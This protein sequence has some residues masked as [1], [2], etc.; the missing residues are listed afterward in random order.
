MAEAVNQGV[1]D[2]RAWC[3]AKGIPL[4]PP[5]PVPPRPTTAVTSLTFTEQMTGFLNPGTTSQTLA[6]YEA[7]AARAKASNSPLTVRLDVTIQDVNQFV[8]SP[9][10]EAVAAGYVDSPLVGGRAAVSGG[11]I[12]LLVD[13]GDPTKKQM[14]YRLIFKGVDGKDYTL[15]GFKDISGAT[16]ASAW[17]ET[18]TLYTT[19]LSGAVPEGAAGTTA[20]SGVISIQP[21][22]FFFR[23]L[24]S[25]RVQGPTLAAQTDALN[26][27]GL[28]FFGKL[29]DVY[30]RQVGPL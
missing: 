6:D 7:A 30:G 23:Q 17:P 12:N 3:K 8:S 24:F 4:R 19:L 22:D 16:F 1:E 2:A 26:R 15:V 27:F 10:H 18:T 28:L 13:A 29:W 14:K 25:F 20:A 11:V 21:Q 5:A 9:K